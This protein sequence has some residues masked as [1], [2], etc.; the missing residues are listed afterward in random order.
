MHSRE[1]LLHTGRSKLSV[2]M[3]LAWPA[4]AEQLLLTLVSYVDTAMVGSLGANAT[5][6]VAVNVSCAWLING[7]LSALGVGYSVQVAHSIGAGK[8]EQA[9]KVV[10]QSMLAVLVCGLSLL[11]LGSFLA[12]F[13]PQWMGAAPE[14]LSDARAYIR[15]IFLALPFQAA[16]VMFSAVLRC[17]GNTR[18]PLMLNTFTN[19]LNILLNFLLIYPGRTLSLFGRSFF[20]PGAGLGV[21]GAAI[22]TASSTALTGTLLALY[23]FL[24]KG[25]YQVHPGESFRPDRAVIRKAVTLGVPVG[26]ERMTISLGHVLMTRLVSVLGTLP[27]AA[28]HVAITAEALCYLPAEGISHAAMTLSGQCVGAREYDQAYEFGKRAAAFGLLLS[29][30]MSLL[31][32]LFCAPLASIFSPDME[33]IGLSAQLLRIISI[34]EPW[35][36]LS[37]VFSGMLRGAEDTR[38][39]FAVSL[40]C[41]WGVR[42]TLSLTAVFLLHWDL[43]ALWIIMG[44]DCTTRCVLMTVRFFSKKWLRTAVARHGESPSSARL[45]L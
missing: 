30:V 1:D 19:L 34:A 29:F 43:S 15:I 28:N 3:F 11:L 2:L 16:A 27:L 21:A 22:A 36:C 20:M 9:R 4:I 24:K 10:R 5:A 39:P 25:P 41:M 14:I 6:A 37:I 42:A 32:W 18:T 23:L 12:P 17:M 44:I 26:L 33:V 8:P 35:F 38:Y 45:A 40:I 7:F 31:L 13:I